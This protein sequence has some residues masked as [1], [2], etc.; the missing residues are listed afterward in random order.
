MEEMVLVGVLRTSLSDFWTYAG[1]CV[2]TGSS[3]ST[4]QI[5]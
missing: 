3:E 5:R 4:D 2:E 1:V